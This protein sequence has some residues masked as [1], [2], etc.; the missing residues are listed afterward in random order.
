MRIPPRKS[1]RR[2]C[3]LLPLCTRASPTSVADELAKQIENVGRA[4]VDFAEELELSWYEMLRIVSTLAGL[5]M[6]YVG[7]IAS[8]A[9]AVV[10][11]AT[12]DW[13]LIPTVLGIIVGIFGVILSW[14][15]L[16]TTY[17][18]SMRT[19]IDVVKDT[20]STIREVTPTKVEI[21][22]PAFVGKGWTT[23]TEGP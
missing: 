19:C 22:S 6:G 18:S 14:I 12:G 4:H 7:L 8:V 11:P 1:R 3:V 21:D 23:K 13:S 5:A 17:F 2:S 16:V 15:G 20:Q 9:G 10:A